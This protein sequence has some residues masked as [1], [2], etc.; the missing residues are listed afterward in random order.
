MLWHMI[1]A[2]A[3][4]QAHVM[5]N[6]MPNSHVQGVAVDAN[7]PTCSGTLASTRQA[8]SECCAGLPSV[9]QLAPEQSS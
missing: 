2:H 8:R 9:R 3:R 4:N 7:L 5:I 6:H 1:C